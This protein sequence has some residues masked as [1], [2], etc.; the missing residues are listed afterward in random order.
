M[1]DSISHSLVFFFRF[2]MELEVY[3][4]IYIQDSV[5]ILFVLKFSL[6]NTFS[7]TNTF[8]ILKFIKTVLYLTL[9][10]IQT[11]FP[12]NDLYKLSRYCIN[13]TIQKKISTNTS[14]NSYIG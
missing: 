9:T 14:M 2:G 4:T 8:S 13:A 1:E 5:K 6:A 11:P 10:P 12:G 3:V 7:I